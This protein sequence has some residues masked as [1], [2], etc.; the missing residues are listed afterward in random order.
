MRHPFRPLFIFSSLLTRAINAARM[1]GL[2]PYQLSIEFLGQLAE[3]SSRQEEI[4]A[5]QMPLLRGRR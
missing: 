3:A 2:D 4:Y 5:P 1:A